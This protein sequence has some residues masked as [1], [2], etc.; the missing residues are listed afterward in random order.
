M[1]A[2]RSN[3]M[4]TIAGLCAALSWLLAGP[5]AAEVYPPH[6]RVLPGFVPLQVE[7]AG[8]T[9]VLH[10]R[11]YTWG[12]HYLP[13]RIDSRGAQLTGAWQLRAIEGGSARALEPTAIRIVSST[14]ERAV[15]EAEGPL[16][17]GVQ[18]RVRTT[19]EYDGVAVVEMSM[20]AK[21]PA[22]GAGLVLEVPVL[23]RPWQQVLA[24][25]A[26]TIRRR[27]VGR[28]GIIG[29]DDNLNIPYSGEFVNVLDFADGERSFWWF[30]DHAE[31]RTW[32]KN[33]ATEVEA[34]AGQYLM[35]QHLLAP[36]TRLSGRRTFE[37]AFLATP[38]KPMPGD[39]RRNRMTWWMPTDADKALHA[40]MFSYWEAG[41][42]YDA[43]PF[44]KL[45]ERVEN[46]LIPRDR[47]LI[48]SYVSKRNLVQQTRRKYGVEL[49]PYYPLHL[50]ST[51]D[52]MIEGKR[53]EW[54]LM[55]PEVWHDMV[56]PYPIRFEKPM[57]SLRAT[58][59]LEHLLAGLTSAI[60]D[61]DVGGFYFDHGMVKDSKNPAHGGWR[62]QNG[63]WQGSLDILAMREFFKRLAREFA[64]RD[65][66]GFVIVHDSNRAIIP[67]Y[68]FAYGLLDGEHLRVKLR[69]GD[70][71]ALTTMDEFRAKFAPGQYGVPTYW[72]AE[73]WNNHLNSPLWYKSEDSR[74][75]YRKMMN[76]ALL[77]DVLDWP[78]SAHPGERAKL[79]NMLD[80]FG[81]TDAEFFGYWRGKADLV[82][83]AEG[84]YISH[85]DNPKTG[86]ALY[87]VG[88][89]N[90]K[91]VD[92]ALTPGSGRPTLRLR[93]EG[94]PQVE[95]LSAGQTLALSI[96]AR[97]YRWIRVRRAPQ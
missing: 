41:L 64:Q 32:V 91:A 2:R 14:P 59:F 47:A 75:A 10:E 25:R 36:G 71:L 70:Y 39:W 11:K 28:S 77:H 30:A 40:K 12:R 87:I 26:D 58:G 50:I 9:I 61:L 78:H 65:K 55:P 22:A 20:D 34:R 15:I 60:D 19:V 66:P 46:N 48:Q 43:V 52:P 1:K 90:D 73:E 72:L 23:Q 56:G 38:V 82:T 92:A 16:A 88:N 7:A 8:N 86:E 81:V 29:R 45:P 85:Y 94:T 67:A 44:A 74:Q 97:D 69:N 3:R 17:D 42:A 62:D 5:L 79:V 93:I 83:Q 31:N 68:S 89:S 13:E 18:M 37:F 21:A 4:K 6:G 49:L 63:K 35:R 27:D 53:A 57:M 33:V 76:L 54:E 80:D 95:D 24:Y 84:V 96:A 51:A